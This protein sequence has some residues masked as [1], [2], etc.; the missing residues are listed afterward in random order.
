MFKTANYLTFKCLKPRI[1]K[2]LQIVTPFFMHITLSLTKP[3]KQLFTLNKKE[4]N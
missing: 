4:F 2:E 3:L 1:K